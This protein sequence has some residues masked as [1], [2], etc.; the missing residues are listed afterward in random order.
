MPSWRGL[1]CVTTRP[2]ISIIRQF[3][4]VIRFDRMYFTGWA[5]PR[6][7]TLSYEAAAPPACFRAGGVHR[8]AA[9]NLFQTLI[10]ATADVR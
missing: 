5:L 10:E 9:P 2:T 3:R 1:G 4:K 8:N 6:I 7:S